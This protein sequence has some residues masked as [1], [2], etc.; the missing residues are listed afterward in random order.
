MA[1]NL[2]KLSVLGL[3]GM[4][5]AQSLTGCASIVSKSDYPVAL[6][7]NVPEA[8]VTIRDRHDKVVEK[9]QTPA[10]VYLPAKA[11][12]FKSAQYTFAFEKP[13]YEASEESL[14]A[15]LDP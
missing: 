14:K 9:V 15:K 7:S 2:M 8:E 5:L 12:Y 6:A 3:S 10:T 4:A 13:G 1:K 11:G